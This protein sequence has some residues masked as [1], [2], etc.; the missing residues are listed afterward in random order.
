M[1]SKKS[2]LFFA[3]AFPIA[4]VI[5]IMVSVVLSLQLQ[6]GVEI[7]WIVVLATAIILDLFLTWRNS[8]DARGKETQG[9]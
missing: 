1:N 5:G 7:D 3:F 6:E 8:R 2:L 4:F 9:S